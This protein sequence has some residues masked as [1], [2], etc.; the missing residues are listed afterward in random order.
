MKRLSVRGRR[1]GCVA[2]LGYPL[3]CAGGE[4]DRQLTGGE[5]NIAIPGVL[6]LLTGAVGTATVSVDAAG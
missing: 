4:H 3:V 2:H 5:E 1:C 6:G